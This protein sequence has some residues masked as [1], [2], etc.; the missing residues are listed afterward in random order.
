MFRKF[1]KLGLG[2]SIGK[3]IPIEVLPKT[4]PMTFEIISRPYV[5]GLFEGMVELYKGVF[6]GEEVIS[7]EL[8]TTQ[9]LQ[10]YPNY[11]PLTFQIP[12]NDDYNV[13]FVK[14]KN[15]TPN[16]AFSDIKFIADEDIN[17]TRL[18]SLGFDENNNVLHPSEHNRFDIT[19][20][21]V[22]ETIYKVID[23]KGNL[24]T[25]RKY[26]GY[27]SN[28]NNDDNKIFFF[29]GDRDDNYD[30]VGYLK[31]K[32]NY[33]IKLP[34]YKSATDYDLTKV[35]IR[36]YL[37]SIDI[38]DMYWSGRYLPSEYESQMT[39]YAPPGYT[40]DVKFTPDD[41]IIL[42]C[43]ASVL[44]PPLKIDCGVAN[45]IFNATKGDKL[46]DGGNAEKRIPNIIINGGSAI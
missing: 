22:Y 39:V 35:V 28:S 27:Y 32:R 24:F 34:Y 10:S 6:E 21:I 31:N 11:T 18:G 25:D 16:T 42:D 43:V 2:A 1:G 37:E 45:S 41:G 40:Y 20:Y 8:I 12:F 30:N 26:V 19:G 15:L 38:E 23:E 17:S 36:K 13:Y 44:I 29:D 4:K 9:Q 5:F 3:S 33:T 46:Y 7:E 14:V